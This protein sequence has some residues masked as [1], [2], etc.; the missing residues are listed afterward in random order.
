MTPF[1][2]S[3]PLG[4][5]LTK[6]VPGED[7][8]PNEAPDTTTLGILRKIQRG[9]VQK[10][11]LIITITDG[12]PAGGSIGPHDTTLRD[13]IRVLKMLLG[14]IDAFYDQKYEKFSQQPGAPYGAPQRQY[15]GPS[16]HGQHTTY[17]PQQQQQG[18]GQQP[19][20]GQQQQL[21]Y[22]QHSTYPPQQQ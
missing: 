10:P 17:F 6:H 19:Q 13:L 2:G 1:Q 12:Q 20:Y 15:G 21:G 7:V 8:F 11:V 16:G 18:C 22:G 5:S 3:A 9:T 4:S 14:A